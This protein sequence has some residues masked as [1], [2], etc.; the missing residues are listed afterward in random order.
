MRKFFLGAALLG[1]TLSATDALAAGKPS[2]MLNFYRP[3]HAVPV[4][5]SAG[6]GAQVLA[7]LKPEERAKLE[8]TGVVVS[9]TL[10]SGSDIKG[11]ITA[12]V[13]VKQPK[14]RVWELIRNPAHQHTFLP[15]LDKAKTIKKEENREL[16]WFQVGVS[17]VTLENQIDHR[18]WPE[19]SRM[20]WG[21][22]P[23]YDNDLRQQDGYYNLY[24]IDD[25]T[26]LMEFGTLLETSALVPKF[27]QDY[28]TKTDLPEAMAAVKKYMDSNGTYK[29]SSWA[30]AAPKGRRLPASRRDAKL[31][32]S[33]LAHPFRLGHSPAARDGGRRILL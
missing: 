21:L 30:F 18:W 28:L 5:V 2:Q 12:Y 11:V 22:D 16:A 9:N 4:T 8:K 6:E 7:A 33:R 10:S 23:N 19:V 14:A 20:A 15:R 29:K 24:A 26:T 17:F 25:K 1:A 3:P 27:V 31:E 13:I 32:K